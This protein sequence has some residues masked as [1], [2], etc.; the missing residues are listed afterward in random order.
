MHVAMVNLTNGWLSG[1]Y[2]KYLQVLVPLLR[3]DPRVRRLDVLAPAGAV[4]EGE[5]WT[6]PAGDHWRGFPRVRRKLEELAPDVVFVPNARWI[7]VKGAPTVVMVRNMEPMAAAFGGNGVKDV[8]RNL[9]RR[10]AARSAC[11][12]ADRVVAI[13]GF[14]RDHVVGRWGVPAGRVGVVPHGVHPPRAGAGTRRLA[15]LAGLDDAPFLFTAGNIRPARGLEDA[16][17]ALAELHRRGLPLRLVIAGVGDPWTVSYRERSEAL[18]AARGLEGHV[19]W[20]GL[21]DAAEMAWCFTRCVGFAMTSRTEACPNTVLE[22]LSFGTPSAAADNPP[23]PEFYGDAA[24]YY[25]PGDGL[26][27]ADALERIARMPEGERDAMRA[28]AVRRSGAFTWAATAR[29]TVDELC[30]VLD[31]RPAAPALEGFPSAILP[32]PLPVPQ[33][34]GSGRG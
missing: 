27:L 13:S 12:R 20:A 34:S 19:I 1:G 2:R 24:L 30:A 16:V 11:R 28:A 32:R 4:G 33:N 6:W 21:L 25:P 15:A 3:A 8:L 7:G 5:A 22:A 23:L 31:R 17:A 10:H 18:V 26:A 14:V 29:R 9:A